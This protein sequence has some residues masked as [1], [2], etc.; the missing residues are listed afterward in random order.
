[1]PVGGA[2]AVA[3]LPVLY[4]TDTSNSASITH[5]AVYKPLCKAKIHTT[6][7][8]E[9]LLNGPGWRRE[10][11]RYQ[12]PPSSQRIARTP[13]LSRHGGNGGSTRTPGHSSRQ[14]S[15]EIRM[16]N[17]KEI[18][19]GL[20]DRFAGFI[21][22]VRR[23]ESQNKALEREIEDIR[24][25]AKSSTS[26][27]KQYEPE[28]QD[29][30][31]QVREM[32][33]QKHQIDLEQKRVEDE[34]NALREKCGEEARSRA[35]AEESIS[36]LNKYINSANLAKQEMDRKAKA[37]ADEIEFVKK[38]HE[39]EVS[40]ILTQMKETRVCAEVSGFGKGELTA[41][42]RAIRTQ[43]EE[44]R[45]LGP[46][47]HSE[48]R[49]SK[50]LAKLTKAAESDREALIATKTEIS[51]YRRQLQTKTVELDSVKGM[52]EALERQLYDLQQR[53]DAE[54]HHY[55]VSPT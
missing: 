19:R 21:E 30:R 12:P 37:L 7:S 36:A 10:E 24:L 28:L 23:L 38:N 2:A 20:N 3:E 49:L 35:E 11:Q 15:P 16:K 39:A 45:A 43:L 53:H 5:R 4:S 52:R 25:K 46:H 13:A 50:Q 6:L 48:Q 41:A 51:Q 8:M 44:G 9:R 40:D 42:L 54:I 31:R 14:V 47:S 1:M 18:L 34:F 29:L 55:Q 33:M 27:A 22:K 17:E 32:A 26:L